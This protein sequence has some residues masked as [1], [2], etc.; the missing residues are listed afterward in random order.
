[1]Q[2]I[3]VT[4][5]K[6]KPYLKR[7]YFGILK[8]SLNKAIKEQKLDRLLRQLEAIVPDISDQYTN[9]LISDNYDVL[10]T[11]AQHAFQLSLVNR[12]INKLNNPLIVD[13]GDSSGN[14]LKYILGLYSEKKDIS[15][16]SVNLD[17]KAVEKIKSKGLNAIHARAEDLAEYNVSADVFICFEILEHLMN[18]FY[19]LHELSTKTSARYLILTVPYAKVSRVGLR[20]I[21]SESKEGANAENTHI[22][23]LCPEDWKLTVK[24]SGWGIVAE[25]IYLQ[26]P[27]KSL[28]RFTKFLW[29]RHDFEG[30]YGLILERDDSWSSKYKDW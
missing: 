27:R 17:A 5:D 26:Y 23:E 28:L 15:C 16:L 12:I 19:F 25:N 8:H 1:M 30:F 22:L 13:I 24:H 10:K 2:L 20:H 6:I 21:R 9:W 14:H 7:A 18:P 3:N 29:K 4:Q 11:R